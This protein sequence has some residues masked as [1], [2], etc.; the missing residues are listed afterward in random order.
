MDIKATYTVA[1]AVLLYY[2]CY[3]PAIVFSIWF[4]NEEQLFL[5][6]WLTFMVAFFSFVS[7]ALNP[8]IYV[9]RSRRNRSAIRQLLKDPCG[10]SAYQENPI[11]EENKARQQNIK[12]PQIEREECKD[13]GGTAVTV[14]A[15]PIPASDARRRRQLTSAKIQIPQSHS[16]VKMAWKKKEDSDSLRADGEVAAGESRRGGEKVQDV[17]GESSDSVSVQNEE[18]N[19]AS[20]TTLRA[21]PNPGSDTRRP[22]SAKLQIHQPH[23]LLKVAWQRTEEDSSSLGEPFAVAW[24]WSRGVE[25]LQDGEGESSGSQRDERKNMDAAEKKGIGTSPGVK[26]RPYSPPVS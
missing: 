11:R 13:R 16:V 3:I 14:N 10:T 18:C 23:R 8:V 15:V 24:Q 17:E 19:K 2:I 5:N 22:T 6:P 21:N 9:S 26:V 1:M 25:K 4:R 12:P 20:A 7:G